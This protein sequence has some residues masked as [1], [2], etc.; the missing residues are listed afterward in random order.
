MIDKETV[1]NF[2]KLYKD[3][4]SRIEIIFYD[5]FELIYHKKPGHIEEWN[6]DEEDNTIYIRYDDSM[7]GCYEANSISLPV[8]YLW[9]EDYKTLIIERHREE[10]EAKKRRE[11]ELVAKRTQE[12]LAKEKELYLK[13]RRKYEKN[14]SDSIT[15]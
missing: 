5:Y 15:T 3:I 7:R 9:T 12:L 14:T 1:E 6:I 8:E 11:E 13:L 4:S 10:Q 2:L